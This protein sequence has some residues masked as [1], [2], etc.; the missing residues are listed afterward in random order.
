MAEGEME[1]KD[2]KQNDI[3][4][5]VI[6]ALYGVTDTEKAISSVLEM[7]GTYCDVSR[8]YI[9]ENSPD[10]SR[11]SNTFEW[12]AEG[13]EPQKDNL[14]DFDYGLMGGTENY[15]RNFDERGLFYCPD[16][17]E[18]PR[19][20]QDYLKPQGIY[21]MLQC[22]L[23]DSGRFCGFIG[24]DEC[25]D[26]RKWTREQ[27]EE[28]NLSAKLIGT[29]L[30]KARRTEDALL[31]EDYQRALDSNVSFIYL[32]D[33]S[34]HQILYGNQAARQ[35]FKT[36]YKGKVCHEFFLKSKKPCPSCP[37]RELG[38]T[39]RAGTGELRLPDG[40]WMLSQASPIH[41]HG[42]DMV[43]LTWTD[44][45][46]QKQAE[47]A[48]R[49]QH[50]EK[51]IVVRHS[52]KHILRYDL[53]TKTAYNTGGGTFR[54]ISWDKMEDFPR[55]A[56][57]A[58][59]FAEESREA[60]EEFA[61]KMTAG[62]PEGSCD[63]QV[64]DE[65]GRL[66]WCHADYTLL[67]GEDGQASYAIVSHYDN[68]ELRE[69]ELAYEKW[70]SD[71][72]SMIADS[73]FYLEGNLTKN[74]VERTEGNRPDHLD[75]VKDP[76]NLQ[77]LL[78]H[79]CRRHAHP[80]D[81]ERALRFFD[82]Q[83]LLALYGAGEYKDQL[84]YRSDFSGKQEWYRVS[85]QMVKDPYSEH[86]KIFA[87]FTNIDQ[88]R[89][90]VQ[91]LT[92]RASRDSLT[93]LLNREAA[94]NAIAE[95]IGALKEGETAA[96][97]M[98]DM[99]NFKEINDTKGHQTGDRTLKGAA[100]AIAEVFRK[101]D[102]LG[103]VGG[104][105]FMV[106][107]PRNAS[108]KLVWNKA[109]ALVE[110][111]QFSV[112]GMS[113][114][115]SVGAALCKDRDTSFSKLYAEADAALYSAKDKGKNCFCIF[116]GETDR[117]GK[118][119]AEGGVS[120]VQ[121]KTLLEYMDGG[122]ILAE[123]GTDV[124][125]TYV[126][127]SFFK[128]TGW[129]REEVGAYGERLLSLVYPEDLPPVI[130]TL[131]RAA[132]SSEPQDCA[133]RAG[134]GGLDWR[135]LRVVRLSVLSDAKASVIGVVSDITDLK[136]EEEQREISEAR[137]RM[138]AE[139]T[140]ATIWEVDIASRTM[141][142]AGGVFGGQERRE[143]TIRDVP[144]GFLESG[145]VHPESRADVF[146][147]FEDLY[148]GRDGKEYTLRLNDERD[149]YVWHRAVF[150][151]LR[152][153]NGRP[154]RSV[155]VL[156][157]MP[158]IDAEM[159]IFEAEQRFMDSVTP[160]I[161]GSVCVNLSKNIVERAHVTFPCA[162]GVSYD[163]FYADFALGLLPENLPHMEALLKREALL[164][165][166]QEGKTWMYEEYPYR[167]ED[168]SYRWHNLA[169]NLLRH[170]VSTDVFVFAYL[171]DV[172]ERRR[173]EMELPE[174][175]RR[176]SATMLY[177]RASMED[178]VE[179]AISRMPE[180]ARCVMTVIEISDLERFKS[181]NGILLSRQL[182]FTVGRLCR[183]LVG[184]DVVLG[185]LEESRIAVFRAGSASS[186]EHRLHLE[187]GRDHARAL[188]EKTFMSDDF[189][190]AWGYAIM[191]KES[192]GFG[193]L[194]RRAAVACSIARG[195][196]RAAIA[197]YTAADGAL[198]TALPERGAEFY[199]EEEKR[200]LIVDDDPIFRQLLRSALEEEY[201]IDEA[202]DGEKALELLGENSYDLVISDILM[203]KRT[204][205]EL[206]EAMKEKELLPATP[207]VIITADANSDSEVKALDLGATDVVVKPF[208][209]KTLQS[210]VRNIIGRRTAARIAEKNKL[211]EL[212]FQQ[213]AESLRM[214]EY[215][216]LTGLLNRQGF[217][218]R[219]RERLGR[220]PDTPFCILRF[221]FDNF[222]VFNDAMGVAA[223]DRLL[224]ALALA[225]RE[226]CGPESV[227]ARLEADHFVRLLPVSQSSPEQFFDWISNWMD[228]HLPDMKLSSHMGVYEIEDPAM[229]V[230]LMCDWAMMALRSIKGNFNRRVAFYDESLRQMLLE[231]Q[232]L[233]GD[234]VPALRNREF[235]L[236]FQPQYNY[237][238]GELT[239]AECLVRWNHPRRGLLSPAAFIPLFESNGFITSLDEYVWEESCRTLRK[240][241]DEGSMSVPVP[242][243]V[244]ISRIDI[245]N[246]QLCE[247]LKT[248]MSR[249]RLP[250]SLLKLEIT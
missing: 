99:D 69:K 193:E 175:A 241:L 239:G 89:Q 248:L 37:M 74:L 214:A 121:I 9:F 58:G 27:V 127:P 55:S 228:T 108:E 81:E 173:W 223:G 174:P 15:R 215:D 22:A 117:P 123:V 92:E 106:Y 51:A 168:G 80:D 66:R 165:L 76:E 234:M 91:L 116:G 122:V 184:G 12:C 96:L 17:E 179:V 199:G 28:L 83:R 209:A 120:A 118:E 246:P 35:A 41:W 189:E 90:E 59:L 195:R 67:R 201:R 126:S 250:A 21:A 240:W 24:Y 140:E 103:R 70:K 63:I 183:V 101:E 227:Y 77:E 188:L 197:E 131:R 244:N 71:L 147:M 3:V 154:L 52:G 4:E 133:Y 38:E 23:L 142:Q 202:E 130:E 207:V 212:R 40:R 20:Q 34:N 190:E 225:L 243:S 176:D 171:R 141:W 79:E 114:T 73:V 160:S 157:A 211:Y 172:E 194:V 162:G 148:E 104:D 167:Q 151:L 205:W 170:P 245:Y 177:T 109:A 56:I 132:E 43:M 238:N 236:Y 146:R 64:Y 136:K 159:R 8:V 180:G 57:E 192:A 203:P 2:W 186:Q 204:G 61:R 14:Q 31:S 224:Q 161:L 53:L 110:A 200:I 235:L 18:L 84:E 95:A 158:N 82:I 230:S 6:S 65:E 155:G 196:G 13:V 45:T 33:P 11:C 229:E 72:D 226:Y 107:L 88:A 29:F 75:G 102:I 112:D 119:I 150:K 218:R 19:A 134:K 169:I 25:R 32:V 216:D 54:G 164:A 47:E 129:S 1:L 86:V 217:Y 206:L 115:A 220:E 247:N 153:G 128:F 49:L 26:N 219:V 36:D 111:L 7:L 16:V 138:A 135:H 198:S 113:V 166:Y 210:R 60:A 124:K 221:D 232:E 249:Y 208:F 231:E 233:F 185:S 222:K 42:R 137:Y 78:E 156:E 62:E 44:I 94:E 187:H 152:D 143:R 10:G 46:G 242:L 87:V 97:F 93:R 163:E 213:Q 30:L 139:L 50:E 68:T 149:G 125:I 5:R 85:I 181:K 182:L 178:L 145:A 237:G 144:R 105:E 39:G 98:I 48:L 191:E 100:D